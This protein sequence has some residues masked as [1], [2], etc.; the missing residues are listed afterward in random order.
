MKINFNFYR[1]LTKTNW[2]KI[3]VSFLNLTYI[4]FYYFIP[5]HL[6]CLKLLKVKSFDE[7]S[8]QIHSI[9]DSISFQYLF[10][11]KFNTYSFYSF[12]QLNKNVGYEFQLVHTKLN[13]SVNHFHREE[14]D[15]NQYCND[16]ESTKIIYVAE[17]R[18]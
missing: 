12:Y 14:I 4:C 3:L 7:G 2:I 11:Y 17:S 15:Q 10:S 5:F 9:H 13:Q 18:N 1:N 16:D 6:N 8:I